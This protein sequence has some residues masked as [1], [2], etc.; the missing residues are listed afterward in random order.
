[1]RVQKMKMAHI[2]LRLG[3]IPLILLK[4][5]RYHRVSTLL[6]RGIG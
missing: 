3:R 5:S 4:S 6:A 2:Q 1:L